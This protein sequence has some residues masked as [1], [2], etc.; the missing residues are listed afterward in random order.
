MVNK[1]HIRKTTPSGGTERGTQLS[2]V[3]QNTQ[4]LSNVASPTA[5]VAAE[6][7]LHDTALS[8]D[9]KSKQDIVIELLRRDDGASIDELTAA[10]GW[11]KHS[12]RGLISGALKKKLG[13]NVVTEKTA[14]GTT[15]RI[16]TAASEASRA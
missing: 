12:V 1:S 6:V 4:P 9:A 3:N 5:D 10:T 2:P 14:E 11:Q 13:L 15:Y 16:T 7:P 8:S